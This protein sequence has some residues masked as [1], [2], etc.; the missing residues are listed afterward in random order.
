MRSRDE[1]GVGEKEDKENKK[2]KNNYWY[3][4]RKKTE[5]EHK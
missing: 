4:N 1:E 5:E 2:T 3:G